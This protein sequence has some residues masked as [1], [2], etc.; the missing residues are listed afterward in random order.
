MKIVKFEKI[1]T[2]EKTLSESRQKQLKKIQLCTGI[3]N[4]DLNIQIVRNLFEI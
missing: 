3:I 1:L 4:L 2:K